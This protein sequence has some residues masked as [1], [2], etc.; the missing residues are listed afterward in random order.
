MSGSIFLIG[1]CES[2]FRSCHYD[3]FILIVL[4][5]ILG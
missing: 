3:S 4:G 1:V 2:T 5:V